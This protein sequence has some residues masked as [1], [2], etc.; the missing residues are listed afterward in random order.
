[1]REERA[2]K[3]EEEEAVK[4]EDDDSEAAEVA[5]EGGKMEEEEDDAMLAARQ[6]VRKEE[7]VRV[8]GRSV[9]KRADS[10]LCSPLLLLLNGGKCEL[11]TMIS[12]CHTTRVEVVFRRVH[13][14]GIR[15]ADRVHAPQ[16]VRHGTGGEEGV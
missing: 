7:G 11:K 4:S 10:R 6:A 16:V 8:E 9:N 1:M 15:R 2:R 3:M 12:V 13:G 5:A 14:I